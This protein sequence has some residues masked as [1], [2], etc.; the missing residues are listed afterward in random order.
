MAHNFCTS[1]WWYSNRYCKA[2]RYTEKAC[3]HRDKKVLII[4]KLHKES[5]RRVVIADLVR[6]CKVD[7]HDEPF[8]TY[9]SQFPA[10]LFLLC[11][12][13]ICRNQKYF[14]QPSEL[15]VVTDL[16]SI[17]F[18]QIFGLF[19]SSLVYISFHQRS[20]RIFDKYWT[21]QLYD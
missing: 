19:F 21:A 17:H 13:F 7:F 12:V 3:F 15:Q 14:N 18:C 4:P 16:L 20:N 5:V 11:I 10:K 9:F 2:F 6:V 8:F 1:L